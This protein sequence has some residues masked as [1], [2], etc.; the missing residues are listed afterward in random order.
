[1]ALTFDVDCQTYTGDSYVPMP[2]ELEAALEVL[3]PV[4]D[5]HPAWRATWFLRI[6]PDVDLFATQSGLIDDLVH[7]GHAIGWHY[8][9]PARRVTEFARRA[10][11][12][13]LDISRMGFGR[14]SNRILGALNDAGFSIDSSAMP[15]PR[16]PWTKRGVDWTGSPDTPYRPSVADYRFPGRPCLELVEIPISC[17][18]VEAPGDTG[19]VIRYLNPAY[20]P[21]MFRPGL[22]EWIAD[23]D[24]LVTITHP[25]EVVTGPSHA[26]LAFDV[27]AFEENVAS[28]ESL[29]RSKG[30]CEFLTLRELAAGEPLEVTTG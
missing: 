21:G 24:H 9:G 30:A 6:D 27:G 22:E 12:H 8:H 4:F 14:G 15:R 3:R 29:A 16:Y 11:Q 13:G 1:M 2:G 26:L 28:T 19:Q 7:N 25:Y 23:H 10:R 20:H 18:A 5:R 17:A